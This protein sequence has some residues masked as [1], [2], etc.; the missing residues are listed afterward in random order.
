[1]FV[2]LD[3]FANQSC[4]NQFVGLYKN[5]LANTNVNIQNHDRT[6]AIVSMRLF[7]DSN[8]TQLGSAILADKSGPNH[9]S[10]GS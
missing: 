10:E 3:E 6:S 5:S 2:K 4:L 7:G 1:M 9:H 8:S